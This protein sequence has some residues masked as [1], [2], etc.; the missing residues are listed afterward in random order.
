[1]PCNNYVG[2]VRISLH[3]MHLAQQWKHTFDSSIFEYILCGTNNITGIGI[4]GTNAILNIEGTITV[5]NNIPIVG[6][7]NIVSGA[8]LPADPSIMIKSVGNQGTINAMKNST[9]GD[10]FR[11][12]KLLSKS[13]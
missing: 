7:L 12:R 5:K 2:T 10:R 8:S 9:G 13:V 4:L 11:Y 6:I 3:R 1:M